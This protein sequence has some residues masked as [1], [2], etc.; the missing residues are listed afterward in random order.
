MASRLDVRELY[1][2]AP[3]SEL[4]SATSQAKSKSLEILSFKCLSPNLLIHFQKLKFF[5]NLIYK[6]TYECIQQCFVNY[7]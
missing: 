1:H 3:Q 4:L 2:S 6:Y 7:K 5:R